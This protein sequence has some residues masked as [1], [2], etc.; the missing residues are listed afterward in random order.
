[1]EWFEKKL[2]VVSVVV[3]FRNISISMLDVYRVISR[4]RKFKTT[5]HKITEYII[6]YGCQKTE[7]NNWLR[8]PS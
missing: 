3:G 2:M 1:M 4:S 8:L 6:L 7:K 5:G